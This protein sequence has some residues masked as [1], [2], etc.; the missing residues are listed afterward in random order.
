MTKRG[1]RL[2]VEARFAGKNHGKGDIR[3]RRLLDRGIIFSRGAGR[4]LSVP[5][6]LSRRGISFGLF[7]EER[8]S[9]LPCDLADL[10][11]KTRT[12]RVTA[13]RRL[14]MIRQ[15]RH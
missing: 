10:E 5:E 9:L 12:M 13:V 15:G 4:H 6:F 3:R 8:P 1:A 7:P 2:I 14:S 11:S